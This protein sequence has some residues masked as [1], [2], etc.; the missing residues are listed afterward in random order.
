MQILYTSFIQALLTFT[1]LSQIVST[2]KVDPP[3]PTH[4]LK[5]FDIN[6]DLPVNERYVEIATYGKPH[7]QGLVD[8][9]HSKIPIPEFVYSAIGW[10]AHRLDPV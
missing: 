6:M 10:L 5:V 2:Q 4:E 7:L 9:I 3:C 8:Y 1:I